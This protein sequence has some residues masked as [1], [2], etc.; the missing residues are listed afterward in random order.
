VLQFLFTILLVFVLVAACGSFVVMGLMQSRRT[1]RLRR[2]ANELGLRFSVDDPFDVLRRYADFALIGCGHSA[3]A[4]DVTYGRLGARLV[5]AFNFRYEVGHGT[6]RTTR[7]YNVVVIESEGSFARVLMWNDNDSDAAPLQARAPDGH[8]GCWS[9]R[10]DA[11]VAAALAE[12]R[13][14]ADHQQAESYEM[15]ETGLMVFAPVSGRLHGYSANIAR[16][17]EAAA[18][19]EGLRTDAVA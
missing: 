15:N 7:H 12:A 14:Q 18:V 4:G 6:R 3:R 9:Y 13:S 5:R 2:E 17:T 16:A 19:L 10:G 8:V 1:R 11:E